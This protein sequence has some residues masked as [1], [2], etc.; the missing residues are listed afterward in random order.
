MIVHIVAM[1]YMVTHIHTHTYPVG[2]TVA[3]VIPSM[4]IHT[5]ATVVKQ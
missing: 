1:A 5:V 3:M 4:V 2:Y